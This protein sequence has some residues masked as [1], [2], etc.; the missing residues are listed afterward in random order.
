MMVSKSAWRDDG[1]Q[2][3]QPERPCEVVTTSYRL[4]FV[5]RLSEVTINAPVD[6][7]AAL[8]S[9]DPLL[10]RVAFPVETINNSV[11]IGT[12]RL[13]FDVEYVPDLESEILNKIKLPLRDDR[14]LDL[15]WRL[16]KALPDPVESPSVIIFWKPTGHRLFSRSILKI[17]LV[18]YIKVVAHKMV[19]PSL[20]RID[21]KEFVPDISTSLRSRRVR[22]TL[23]RELVNTAALRAQTPLRQARIIAQLEEAT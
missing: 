5:L 11:C 15:L 14:K 18:L 16:G 23:L 10:T 7:A 13:E 21:Q 17:G 3:R 22:N 4:H 6:Y 20:Q 12:Y 19:H 1:A 9:T 8:R 2:A